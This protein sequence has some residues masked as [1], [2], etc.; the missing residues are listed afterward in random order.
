MSTRGASVFF[1]A[2]ACALT[3]LGALVITTERAT[4]ISALAVIVA[5]CAILGTL[6]AMLVSDKT[7]KRANRIWRDIFAREYNAQQNEK[8]DIM[9]EREELRNELNNTKI[10][11]FNL[12]YALIEDNDIREIT[13]RELSTITKLTS[14][15]SRAQVFADNV[16]R[17]Y[18]Q[19]GLYGYDA[20]LNAKIE[21]GYVDY[22]NYNSTRD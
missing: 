11:L 4:F 16:V 21:N 22:D 8:R 13:E 14:E 18:S 19:D 6:G 9:R 2:L 7:S 1:T 10:A 20:R 17:D 15:Q 12:A 5:V 3:T